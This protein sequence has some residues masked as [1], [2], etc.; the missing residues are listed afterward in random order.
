MKPETYLQ[1]DA[2]SLHILL[3][4]MKEGSITKAANQLDLTQSA[5]SHAL[6]KLRGVFDDPLFIRAG[7]GIKPTPRA[8]EITEA[9]QPIMQNLSA[10]TQVPEFRPK[11]AVIEWR[12]AANDFQRDLILP[13]F[14][15]V[16]SEQVKSFSLHIEPLEFPEIH[17][18]REDKLDLMLSP[19]RPEGADIMQRKLFQDKT[20][21][22]FDASV[23]SAPKT[24]AD[25]SEAAYIGLSFLQNKRLRD[26]EQNVF[27]HALENNTKVRVSN[28]SGLSSFL[29]GSDLLVIAP[30]LM[31]RTVLADFAE[32]EIPFENVALDM[33][34]LWHKRHQKDAEHSWLR[35]QLSVVGSALV[36]SV[37]VADK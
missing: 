26:T 37:S 30:S 18:M 23:R 21:C 13:E 12:L 15:R 24:E 31:R 1:L 33:Y 8:I 16:V 28:F 27:G 36:N 6:E 32:V 34:M 4:I 14:Y 11:E 10:L 9:L 29:R 7:R 17:L 35:E 25:Y 20:S 5:V 19:V 3:V 2:W 22:F